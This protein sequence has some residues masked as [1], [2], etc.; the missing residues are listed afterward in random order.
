MPTPGPVAYHVQFSFFTLLVISLGFA[1]VAPSS[2]LLVTHTVRPA[3]LLPLTIADSESV[4]RLCVRRSQ[5]VPGLA[6]TTGH[7]LPQ[8]FSA[9]SQ[10]TCGL[11]QVLPPSV[12]RFRSKSMSPAS[13][14][15]ALRPSQKAR[16]VP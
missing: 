3:L 14:P 15:P 6:S 8:V 16:S 12:L 9:S 2:V 11:L 4:P 7:G 13:L 10:T 5:T 1:Q